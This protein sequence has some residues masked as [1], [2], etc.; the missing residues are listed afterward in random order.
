MQRREFLKVGCGVCLLGMA[1]VTIPGLLNQSEAKTFSF[2]GV[3]TADQTILVPIDQMNGLD[4]LTVEVNAWEANIA[5]HQQADGT[6]LSLLLLCTHMENNLNSTGNGYICPAHGSRYDL[7]GN[8]L[9]GP[10]SD[11]LT[12]FPTTVVNGQIV[13]NVKDGAPT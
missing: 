10:A 3:I 6:Y 1:G 12:S 7:N 4:Y 9:V 5:V 11:P 8:V 13:I 2:Q